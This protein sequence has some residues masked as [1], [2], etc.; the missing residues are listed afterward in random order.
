MPE[1]PGR[2]DNAAE[3]ILY[4]WLMRNKSNADETFLK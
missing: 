1:N 4:K 2:L 3:L